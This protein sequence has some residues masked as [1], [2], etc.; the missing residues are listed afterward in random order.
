MSET[1]LRDISTFVR[2]KMRRLPSQSL[3]MLLASAVGFATGLACVGLKWSI[4]WVSDLMSVFI[5]PESNPV[6]MVLP[7]AG[8]VLAALFSQLVVGEN[9]SGS[10]DKLIAFL[11]KGGADIKK[12]HIYGPLAANVFTL[13]FGGSAGAEGPIAVSGADAAAGALVHRLR[14]GCRYRSHIQGSGGRYVVYFGDTAAA[15]HLSDRACTSACLPCLGSY[16]L[17]AYRLYF[18]CFFG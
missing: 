2:R 17:Y 7:L 4:K 15:L 5:S 6:L 8:L 12:S 13:G 11:R 18:R 10:T 9:L 14:G 16:L 3:V 1:K